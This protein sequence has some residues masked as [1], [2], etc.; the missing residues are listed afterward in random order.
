MRTK[1]APGTK[2]TLSVEQ[3]QRFLAS[4][5][6]R[7]LRTVVAA[8]LVL[9]APVLFRLPVMRRHPL[10]RLLEMLGGAA[11]I[12]K[13][14]ESLRDWDPRAARPIVIEVDEDGTLRDV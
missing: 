12:V 9:S 11:L 13:F 8:G 1:L 4:D 10:L 5:A 3:L 6:G 14:A 2:V 7:R